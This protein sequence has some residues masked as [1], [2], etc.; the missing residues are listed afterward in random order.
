MVARADEGLSSDAFYARQPGQVFK[1]LP[2]QDM[3]VGY[4]QGD[5]VPY[6]TW[7]GRLGQRAV[8]VELH[9]DELVVR[10][11]RRVW[12]RRLS[13]AAR[14]EGAS[15]AALDSKGVSIFLKVDKIG[16]DSFICLESL[17]DGAGQSVPLRSVYLLS[18]PLSKLNV[19]QLPGLYGSCKGLIARGRG[20]YVVPHWQRLPE[21]QQKTHSVEWL[22][23]AGRKGFAPTGVSEALTELTLDRFVRDAPLPDVGH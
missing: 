3:T 10:S 17:P 9:G 6:M 7:D 21:G 12:H 18:D 13:K 16:R 4:L 1:A 23:L 8:Y 11:G 2:P 22:R 14:V 20:V 15:P 5:D 19:Y